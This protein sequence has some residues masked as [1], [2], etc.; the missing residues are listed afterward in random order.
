ML[1]WHALFSLNI[2][3]AFLEEYEVYCRTL[4]SI[5][6]KVEENDLELHNCHLNTYHL[7]AETTERS[8][9]L[10]P[11]TMLHDSKTAKQMGELV[12]TLGIPTTCQLSDADE[13]GHSHFS[14][15]IQF[16]NVTGSDIMSQEEPSNQHIGSSCY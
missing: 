15:K 8:I 4:K 12:V 3:Y 10:Q 5:G 6:L 11:P 7:V 13:Q 1:T 9:H 16:R 2:A 14:M